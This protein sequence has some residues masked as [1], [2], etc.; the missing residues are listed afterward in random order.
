MNGVAL[1]HEGVLQKHDFEIKK[2]EIGYEI[3]VAL[4]GRVFKEDLFSI[5]KDIFGKPSGY[6]GAKE[7]LCSVSLSHSFP[8]V[9][10]CV[11]EEHAYV[12]CDIERLRPFRKGV[13]FLTQQEKAC[14]PKVFGRDRF[15]TLAWTLKESILKALGTGI[16]INPK[17]IDVSEVLKKQKKGQYSILINSQ[18]CEMYLEEILDLQGFVAVSVWLDEAFVRTFLGKEAILTP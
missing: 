9:Y 18:K 15:V 12:G 4:G 11:S 10:A 3:L 13:L 17:S 1:Y 6:Y 7:Q 8:Y 14:H 2:S 16:R 5:R